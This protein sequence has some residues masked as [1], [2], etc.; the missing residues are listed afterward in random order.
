MSNVP[1][2]QQYVGPHG[3]IVTDDDED[4][5]LGDEE[6]FFEDEDGDWEDEDED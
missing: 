5:I 2:E 4:G 6:E 1:D 3:E